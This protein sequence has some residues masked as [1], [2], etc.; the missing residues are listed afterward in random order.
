[1]E[2][3]SFINS[4]L[5]ITAYVGFVHDAVKRWDILLLRTKDGLI[6]NIYQ[7]AE[8]F[9]VSS[10]VCIQIID[11]I[12]LDSVRL[13]EFEIYYHHKCPSDADRNSL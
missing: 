11:V 1:M 9:I 6:S 2:L 12:P 10:A 7:T 8:A 3:A 13:Y 5:I 4:I